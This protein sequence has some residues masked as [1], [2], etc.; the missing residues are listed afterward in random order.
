MLAEKP[1]EPDQAPQLLMSFGDD[2]IS[3]AA[4]T[5]STPVPRQASAI[6]FHPL[7]TATVNCAENLKVLKR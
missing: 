5:M 2:I 3:C 1:P 6:R 4:L 7:Q